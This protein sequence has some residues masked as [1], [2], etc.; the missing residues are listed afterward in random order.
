MTQIIEMDLQNINQKDIDLCAD[1]LRRGG[2][3]AFPTETVYGLGAN[4]L[5]PAAIGKIFAA[6]GRPSDNPLIVHIS[7]TADVP[8][9]V[10]GI[11]DLALKAMEAFWPGPLTILFR[12]SSLVPKE[13][14]AGLETV[15]IR[16][17]S[18]PIAARLIEAAGIPVAAPSANTSGK[19]SPT[20]AAH[21]IE[22]LMGKVDAI[23]SGGSSEVGL[24]STVLDLT[25][26]VPMIL[27]PGGVTRE[28]LEEVLEQKVL[29]DPALSAGVREDVTPK[30]PGMKYTH[31]SPR[32]SVLVVQ[33]DDDEVARKINQL[34][35]EY[36][37]EG[38][39][40]GVICTEESYALYKG[41][42]V[43]SMGSRG[44]L[45]SIASNLFRVLREFDETDVEVI[46]AEAVSE[47]EVG[48]AVMNRLLKAS[49]HQVINVRRV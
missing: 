18:H 22:D 9:L 23:I 21:V 31:Y 6:K 13:I 7:K 33:G 32:A 1:I 47:A 34:M 37:E 16:I 15:G 10:E 43:K 19:P 29:E 49:G 35:S 36:M 24:E 20:L 38:R 8:P 45:E 11:S 14:T 2:T 3:V 42:N 41:K 46:L 40:V 39:S 25:G 30:S 5:D 4:A 27:R 26:E 44:C 12:K 17:P 28:K 48:R